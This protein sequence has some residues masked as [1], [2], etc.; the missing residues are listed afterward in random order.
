VTAAE[1]PASVWAELDLAALQDDNYRPT[2]PEHVDALAAKLEAE[3]F[4]PEHGVPIVRPAGRRKWWIVSGHHR[5]AAARQ[6]GWKSL[7]CVVI[8]A[9]ELEALATAVDANSSRRDAPLFDETVAFG[10]LAA[11]GMSTADIATRIG[12]STGYVARRLALLELDPDVRML[13]ATQG[14]AW[15]EALLCLS[16]AYQREAVRVIRPQM[17][18]GQ[19]RKVVEKM[20]ERAAAEAAAQAP[21][22]DA[23]WTLTVEEWSAEAKA[24]E[25][26]VDD[27]SERVVGLHE[28]CQLFG[29]RREVVRQWRADGLM[30]A[31]DMEVNRGPAWWAS[32]LREWLPEA[33][34]LCNEERSAAAHKAWE[35]RRRLRNRSK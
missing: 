31:A 34:V 6:L 12:R 8:S 7:P 13:A 16:P 33:A 5:I 20:A 18:V 30:P 10:R 21:L 24:A 1:S 15:A 27:G 14:F 4:R 19:F 23:E 9:G 22:F 3:G 26:L 28:A 11:G 2:V 35:T 29:W 17:S 25:G 32:T